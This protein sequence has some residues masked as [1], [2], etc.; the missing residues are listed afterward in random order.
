MKYATGALI[1]GRLLSDYDSVS[2]QA[3]GLCQGVKRFP[4][5]WQDHAEKYDVKLADLFR[6]LV[7][8]SVIDARARDFS[9]RCA[10]Q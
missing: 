7:N 5:M 8:V 3:R 6:D 9:R 2:T 1:P 10:S 4:Q